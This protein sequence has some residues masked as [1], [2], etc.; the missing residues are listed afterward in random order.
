MSTALELVYEYRHLM[1]KCRTGTG[2]TLDEIEAVEAI[3]GL[4]IPGSSPFEGQDSG[5][6][7]RLTA[8]L[9]GGRRQIWDKAELVAARLD[10]L[11]LRASTYL[12]AGSVIELQV[13]DEE[14]RLSYRFKGRVLSTGDE[15]ATPIGSGHL[16]VLEL[17]GLPLLVRR[18][19]RS[20]KPDP[21]NSAGRRLR[22]EP[23]V[24]AA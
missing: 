21:Q 2:L 12:E 8:T 14:L 16:V 23:R 3:E 17:I 10:Q 20:P 1:G 5:L 24:Q 9:R 22:S 13:D 7:G 18:G 4:F 11:E 19:P 6:A 15:E